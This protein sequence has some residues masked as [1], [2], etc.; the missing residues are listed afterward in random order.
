LR[1]FD[2]KRT[3]ND[4]PALDKLAKYLMPGLDRTVDVNTLLLQYYN[5]GDIDDKSIG[6]KFQP[7]KMITDCKLN[8]QPA[9]ERCNN[10]YKKTL[11]CEQVKYGANE[12]NL[13][14]FVTPICPEGYQRY[15]AAKCL[16]MCN[17]TEA[18]EADL[19]AG[20]DML[21]ERRWTKTNYCLKKKEL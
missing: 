7:R 6:F 20:E 8:L 19:Q 3:A 5:L 12:F 10:A 18:I 2:Y 13:A 4:I 11:V 17:Y 14:P 15:G 9:I 21:Y 1:Q 16:R